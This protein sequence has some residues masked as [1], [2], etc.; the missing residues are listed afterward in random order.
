MASALRK[1]VVLRGEGRDLRFQVFPPA[2]VNVELFFAQ[3][4]LDARQH[5]CL[6]RLVP[7]LFRVSP[8]L[9]LSRLLL[10][11]LASDAITL[12]VARLR[13][14]I[15]L[16]QLDVLG[17][18]GAVLEESA[19]DFQSVDA[20]FQD[21]LLS[22]AVAHRRGHDGLSAVLDAQ[23]VLQQ[24]LVLIRRAAVQR[25]V[26]PRQQVSQGGGGP[27]LVLEADGL[28]RVEAEARRALALQVLELVQ[29]LGPL[30]AVH[31][32][33]GRRA[34]RAKRVGVGLA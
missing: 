26:Q 30:A 11:A 5:G 21:F 7:E 8:G 1:H 22:R 15:G 17:V 16:R 29:R 24:L 27:E 32:V 9:C 13:V 2:D 31:V 10:L 19:V 12:E 28:R 4:H 18:D 6:S 33:E 14:A 23:H 20:A 34:R 25:S 3:R